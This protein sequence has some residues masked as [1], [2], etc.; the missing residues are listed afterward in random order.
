M[1]DGLNDHVI[2]PISAFFAAHFCW[3]G[4]AYCGTE[5]GDQEF[6]G[7]WQ[8]QF[9]A[10][11]YNKVCIDETRLTEREWMAAFGRQEAKYSGAFMG[12]KPTFKRVDIRDMDFWKVVDDKI[13]C[14]WGDGG[15]PASHAPASRSSE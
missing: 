13:L 14:N 7:S 5:H 1:V 10:A 12:I 4:N 3:H 9:Q 2:D 6:Q 8:R 11:I 15:S